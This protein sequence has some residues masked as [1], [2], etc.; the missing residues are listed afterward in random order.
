MI[1]EAIIL[2][3][4]FGTRLKSAVPDI[5]KP[6]AIINDKPFL[7]YL[8]RYLIGQGI[9]KAILSVGYKHEIIRD[10]FSHQYDSLEIVYCVEK[11][12]LGTGGGIKKALEFL[13]GIDTFV[14]NGD[15]LFT[16]NL[17]RFEELHFSHK[18]T[19]SI[20]LKL[21]TNF[22]RYGAVS[23]DEQHNVLC[24]EEKRQQHSGWIN[25]G[26]YILNKNIFERAPAE[27]NFSF[28]ID[29][30]AAYVNQLRPTGFPFDDYFIDIGLPEDYD[31][32]QK[33]L[34]IVVRDET[35]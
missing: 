25:A 16:I 28:E 2:A 9:N 18:S 4:G 11:Q 13:V 21:M 14:L 3:G 5:P 1:T 35:F 34:K 32:A 30:L 29:F 33:D 17:R 23:I 19:I 6:M 26:V 27:D 12:P 15:T 8:L 24:F 20:A 10:Y 22:D 31:R 7:E